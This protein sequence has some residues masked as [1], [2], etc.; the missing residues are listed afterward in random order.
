MVRAQEANYRY[1]FLLPPRGKHEF[2]YE[3]QGSSSQILKNFLALLHTHNIRMSNM[4]SSVTTFEQ[5]ARFANDL[6]G[7][8]RIFR[9]AQS[10][11]Q[12]ILAYP[13]TAHVVLDPLVLRLAHV[14]ASLVFRRAILQTLQQRLDLARRYVRVFR[15]LDTFQR[16]RRL[17]LQYQSPSPAASATTAAKGGASK[18]SY[19]PR[20]RQAAEWLDLLGSTF[21]GMYLLIETST[22]L[23][24]MQVDG[25]QVWGREGSLAV[26][27][28]AQRFWFFTLACGVL[29]GIVRIRRV[30]LATPTP[31]GGYGDVAPVTGDSAETSSKEKESESQSQKKE[32]EKRCQLE[33][34]RM[35]TKLVRGVVSN[36]IDIIIPG[37]VVGWFRVS[38]GIVALAMFVTTISTSVDIW[39]RCGGNL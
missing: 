33:R 39:E 25:L 34:S 17:L 26:N 1:Y 7:L 4:A 11:V 36:I 3:D 12:I 5:S 13:T 37:V 10:V 15:F 22:I 14:P 30:L 32:L 6:A 16:V 2:H 18:P 31:S 19:A 9:L 29:A 23:D 24:Y 35:L 20:G 27:A 21:N 28:E 8:E 38:P